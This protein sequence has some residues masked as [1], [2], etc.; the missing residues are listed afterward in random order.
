MLVLRIY[1]R[2]WTQ[3]VKMLIYQKQMIIFNQV[4]S[5]TYK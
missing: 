2:G 1:E 4:F 3:T 5:F